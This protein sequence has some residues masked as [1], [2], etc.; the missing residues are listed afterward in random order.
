MAGRTKVMEKILS[1]L[2]GDQKKAVTSDPGPVLVVAGPGTGKTHTISFRV[3]YMI[4]QGQ[5]M[6]GNMAVLTFTNKAAQ[7]IEERIRGLLGSL[8]NK[9]FFGTIHSLC[10]SIIKEHDP[11]ARDAGLSI[12]SSYDQQRIMREVKKGYT[13]FSRTRPRSLLTE[14]SLRK[15]GLRPS[16]ALDIS[17]FKSLYAAYQQVLTKAGLM[18]YDDLLLKCVSILRKESGVLEKVRNRYKFLF[19]DEYQDINNVQYRLIRFITGDNPCLFAVG[20]ADQAIYSF[21]GANVQNFMDFEKDFPQTARTSLSLNYRNPSGILDPASSVIS[22]NRKRL[23]Y[24]IN[25]VSESRGEITVCRAEDEKQEAKYIVEQIEQG[26]GGTSMYQHDAGNV[27]LAGSAGQCHFSDFAVLY[28]INSQGRAIEDEFIHRG[29]PYQRIGAGRLFE[30]IEVMIVLSYLR[31]LFNPEDELSLI[32][33]INVPSRGLGEVSL[34]FFKSQAREM[35]ISIMEAMKFYTAK[36]NVSDLSHKQFRELKNFMEKLEWW[37]TRCSQLSARGMIHSVVNELGL[38]NYFTNRD[39]GDNFS[40][41]LA[42][43]SDL[44]DVP[45]R[46]SLPGFLESI[47]LINPSDEFDK[48]A[49]KVGLMTLHTAKGLEFDTV[50]IAG[51]EEGLIPMKEQSEEDG[52]NIEEERRLF[53]VGLTRAKK[54]VVL[55]HTANRFI[56]GRRERNPVSRFVSEIP[57]NHLEHVKLEP[58]KKR[59]KKQDDQL[60]LF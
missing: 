18:D 14:I 51:V 59:V 60:K 33:V 12:V 48:R 36:D 56:M 17:E 30:K 27:D 9:V 26:L 57:E 34:T 42:L 25:P 53:Y 23:E 3:A 44:G 45:A 46:E 40:R 47:A 43:A 58:R 19:I 6:P 22:K 2:N 50:F 55:T 7:E 4:S 49:N 1:S 15:N 28:R 54:R 52:D 21:R 10:L 32:R 41:L 24:K 16:R 29:I 38:E 20:D 11:R 13:P 31:I 39:A 8:A 35:Q 37:R 5:A